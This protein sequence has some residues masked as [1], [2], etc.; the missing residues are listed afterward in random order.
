MNK[1]LLIPQTRRQLVLQALAMSAVVEAIVW[2][3]SRYE[4]EVHMPLWYW[5]GVASFNFV[6]FVGLLSF[7]RWLHEKR[8]EWTSTTMRWFSAVMVLLGVAL[9]IA[10]F[11]IRIAR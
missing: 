4:Y 7:M 1:T 10:A 11:Y 8:E 3:L 2:I 9:L 5:P 6:L